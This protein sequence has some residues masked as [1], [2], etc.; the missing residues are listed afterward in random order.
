MVKTS[1]RVSWLLRRDVISGTI[2]FFLALVPRAIGLNVFLT[3]DESIWI[4]RTLSFFIALLERDYAGTAVHYKPGV[5]TLWSGVLGLVA[6]Y[7][8]Q[9]D[10]WPGGLADFVRAMFPRSC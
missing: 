9:A 6:D 4:R 10:A 2:L 8:L 1:E 7:L 3:T 5:T